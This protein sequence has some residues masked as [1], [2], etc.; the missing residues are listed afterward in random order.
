M[1][2]F[3]KTRRKKHAN[4]DP[5]K[6]IKILSTL[7]N[8]HT[9]RCVHIRTAEVTPTILTCLYRIVVIFFYYYLTQGH[10]NVWQKQKTRRLTSGGNIIRVSYTFYLYRR[11]GHRKSPK[12]NVRYVYVCM[13]MN[14]CL[15]NIR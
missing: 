4:G 8:T 14:Y 3:S 12:N 9:P 15:Q 5:R 11:G 13:C 10:E 7:Y 1:K 6:R 2:P